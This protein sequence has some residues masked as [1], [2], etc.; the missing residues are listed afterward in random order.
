MSLS[1][2]FLSI[3]YLLSFFGV[4]F[5]VVTLGNSVSYAG[6]ST[7]IASAAL[8]RFFPTSGATFEAGD[9]YSN[10]VSAIQTVI[11]NKCL[12]SAGFQ[13]IPFSPQ[14]YVGNNT[15]FPNLPYLRMHGF[16]ASEGLQPT[17]VRLQPEGFCEV[18]FAPI[19]GSSAPKRVDGNRFTN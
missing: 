11:Y 18:R 10:D 17:I 8:D 19:I 4:I 15:E 14:P 7:N 2:R 5:V 9:A 13:G 12:E 6:S 1:R 16:S 3:R